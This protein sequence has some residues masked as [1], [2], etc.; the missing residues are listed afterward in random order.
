MKATILLVSIFLC[1]TVSLGQT[2]TGSELLE[3]SISHH[4]P[5]NQW[6]SF[7]DSLFITMKT[8]TSSDRN[9]IIHINLANEYFYL[10]A[11]TDTISTEYTL[12]KTACSMALNGTQNLSESLKKTHKM[13][14]KRATMLKDY[15]TYLYGLPMKLKDPGTIIDPKVRLK[16]FKGKKYLVLKASYEKDVGEDTWYFYF[17]QHNYAMEV[18]QFF[19]DETKNDG[20]YI[21][22]NGEE[23][24][25]NI[26]MPKIRTWY[27]NKGDVYLGKDILKRS[28]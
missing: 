11:I 20:E 12:N 14:C 28:F 6:G 21:L 13:S 4:D 24:I 23:D 27:M 8:P 10:K 3:K 19:H 17:N 16:E 22:L 2:L 18:Y 9:S 5:K 26:K 1:S 25:G 15:Y 7:N